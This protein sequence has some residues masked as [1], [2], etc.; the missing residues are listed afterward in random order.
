[1]LWSADP[2]L[3]AY[4][5]HRRID[6]GVFPSFPRPNSLSH[7]HPFNL[8]VLSFPCT[9][10]FSCSQSGMTCISC[11]THIPSRMVTCHFGHS[12][13][14]SHCNETVFPLHLPP[15]ANIAPVVFLLSG[16]LFWGESGDLIRTSRCGCAAVHTRSCLAATGVLDEGLLWDLMGGWLEGLDRRLL[17]TCSL[18]MRMKNVSVSRFPVIPN[19]AQICAIDK[20]WRTRQCH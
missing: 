4:C 9:V 8:P 18:C 20:R 3:D 17:I 11:L 5:Q 19:S 6:T 2:N 12:T 7:L 15:A 16:C 14:W 10:S 13:R 1:M